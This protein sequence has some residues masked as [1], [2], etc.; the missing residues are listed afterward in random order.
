MHPA[1]GKLLEP[2]SELEAR[3]S[4]LREVQV[5]CPLELDLQG[6]RW[7]CIQFL[8]TRRQP[9]VWSVSK[10]FVRLCWNLVVPMSH[11]DSTLI[12]VATWFNNHSSKTEKC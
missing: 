2:Y 8:T 6:I 9:V 7:T 5:L 3:E 4:R 10:L 1:L 11:Q 12:R